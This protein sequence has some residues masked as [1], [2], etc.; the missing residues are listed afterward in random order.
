MNS[1]R[2]DETQDVSRVVKR[3]IGRTSYLLVVNRLVKDVLSVRRRQIVMFL[4][5]VK[6][7]DCLIS[8]RSREAQKTNDAPHCNL[9]PRHA[10]IRVEDGGIGKGRV[11][12]GSFFAGV[13]LCA[14]NGTI[15]TTHFIL[16]AN[17]ERH[18]IARLKRKYKESVKNLQDDSDNALKEIR[19]DLTEDQKTKTLEK[20]VA[21]YLVP[22]SR[23]RVFGRGVVFYNGMERTTGCSI[24]M[25]TT[26]STKKWTTVLEHFGVRECVDTFRIRKGCSRAALH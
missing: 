24:A 16:S 9:P 23:D 19:K 18:C 14:G 26:R 7:C 15:E 5:S 11:V 13:L 17:D 4:A 3:R 1:N 25:S 21:Q 12:V 6:F 2:G 10:R 8:V 20:I 22:T